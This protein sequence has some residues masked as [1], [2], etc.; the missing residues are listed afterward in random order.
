MNRSTPFGRIARRSPFAA[1]ERLRQLVLDTDGNVSAIG[2]LLGLSRRQ[3]QRY[4]K[5]LELGQVVE[6]I[7]VDTRKTP[8]RKKIVDSSGAR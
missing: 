5:S 6:S 4:V 3:V 1:T 2:R 8:P 7:R